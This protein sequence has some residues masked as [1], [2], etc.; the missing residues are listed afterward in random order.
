MVVILGAGPAGA[1]AAIKLAL[2]NIPCIVIDKATFPR[3]KICGDGI[4]HR[5]GDIMRRWLDP[6]VFNRFAAAQNIHLDSWGLSIEGTKGNG[7]NI[8][9]RGIYDKTKDI[10]SGFVCRRRE[11]DN[12][13]VEEMKRSPLVTF[14]DNTEIIDF[15]RNK[16]GWF[17]SDKSGKHQIQTELLIVADGANSRFA[18]HIAGIDMDKA[19]F[20]ASV[21][22]YYRGVTDFHADNFLEFYFLKNFLPGY[23]WIF[24]LPNNE[25]NVG[26]AI[27]SNEVSR[28]KLNLK[29]CLQEVLDSKQ[30]KDRFT[31]AELIG[32]IQGF[33]LPLASKKR[34]LTGKN[35]IL[36]G[37]A[38]SLIDPLT[39]E[40]IANAMLSG[41]VAA[42][43]AA[44]CLEKNDFSAK[45]LKGYDERIYRMRGQEFRV[46]YWFQRRF[47][48][49]KFFN[50]LAWIVAKNQ[51]LA[52]TFAYVFNDTQ[53]SKQLWNP[54]F[55]WKVMRNRV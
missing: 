9:Y 54:K 30:F 34:Q 44:V 40:G 51:P 19:H 18:R 48:S 28:R 24:P 5:V 31:K 26:I 2:L 22:A 14:Y 3:D 21:K 23:F 47:R 37:D 32:E 52:R 13:L 35:Y 43:Q 1:S 55:W 53:L 49:E 42:E 17:L 25:A 50:I 11:F 39:G 20:M 27:V 8:G 7:F 29:H 46:S 12:F 16:N 36:T 33:G 41:A 38:A 10:P 4:S 15:Q 45:I 6:S